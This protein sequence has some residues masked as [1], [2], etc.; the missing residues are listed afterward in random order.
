MNRTTSTSANFLSRRQ[1]TRMAL[2]G[3]IATCCGSKGRA[4]EPVSQRLRLGTIGLFGRHL[5]FQ[6]PQ[7]WV[8]LHRQWGFRAAD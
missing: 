1:F 6:D 2:A 3:A 8:A 4:A 5:K 7:Q